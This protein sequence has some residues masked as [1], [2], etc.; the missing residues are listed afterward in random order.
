M[1]R[2]EDLLSAVFKEVTEEKEEKDE[3][4]YF[5]G[6]LELKP[7][8]INGL[9]RESQLAIFAGPFGVG[10]SPFLIDLAYRVMKGILFHGREVVRRPICMIDFESA[11]PTF[12]RN[13]MQLAV[14]FHKG[15]PAIPLELE[16]FVEQGDVKGKWATKL[17]STIT[18]RSPIS[19]MRGVLERKPSCLFIID[20]LELL[21]KVDTLKKDA[22]LSVITPLRKLFA[23]FPRSAA[24][25][26]FNLRKKNRTANSQPDLLAN[27]R[28][29]L[30]EV[31]GSLDIVNRSDVR[32]GMDVYRDDIRVVNGIRRGEPMEPLLLS[33]VAGM[34]DEDLAGFEMHLLDNI[35]RQA[36]LTDKQIKI[37]SSLPTN[38]RM[39]EIEEMGPRATIYR[40]IKR[41]ESLGMVI[42]SLDG[43]YTKI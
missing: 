4:D 26:V 7:Y 5:S 21:F 2:N 32:L 35:D 37:W 25:M 6:E 17:R 1:E 31:C 27:P 13:F 23:E 39:K 8:I 19:L 38:F 20:P 36:T 24:I 16:P 9:L 11:E 14:R 43:S 10:K 28:D 3:K 33:P 22:I 34:G 41:L 29:W 30:E 42:R 15:T 18:S 40:T 12:K